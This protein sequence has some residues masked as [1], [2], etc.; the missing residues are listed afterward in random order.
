MGDMNKLRL[1]LFVLSVFCLA[2]IGCEDDGTGPDVL[3]D[4]FDSFNRAP[5][6]QQQPDT[7]VAVGDTLRLR[8]IAHDPDGDEIS[9]RIKIYV[10]NVFGRWPDIDF[11]SSTGYFWFAPVVGDQPYPS[12]EFFA[13]DGRDGESSTK[14]EVDISY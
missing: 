7:S 8:A 3:D 1:I 13:R 9:F 10:Q 12:F 2:A 4:P 6:I 14:F 5:I 11:N